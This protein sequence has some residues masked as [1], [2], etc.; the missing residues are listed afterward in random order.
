MQLGPVTT[1]VTLSHGTLALGPNQGGQL[2]HQHGVTLTVP[3]GAVTD[4]TR[5]RCRPLF[6]DTQPISSPHGLM[7][8]HRAFELTAFRFG[9]EVRQF[10]RPLTIT[11]NYT[12]TGLKHET[13]R[14]WARTGSGEP[15]TC[16]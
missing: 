9:Q 10:R 5:F 1:V 15:W 14:L 8:A 2:R 16:G 3:P 13:L 7:F 6:T 12:D 11:V 4:T